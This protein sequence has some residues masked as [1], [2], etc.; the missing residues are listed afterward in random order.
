MIS[1]TFTVDDINTVLTVF[2]T[3]QIRRYTG[4]GTPESPVTD[5]VAF[6]EYTTV[7]GHDVI[8][9]TEGVSVVGLRSDFSQYYFTDP[10]GEASDWYISRYYSSS[11]G[12]ISGWSDA[13]LGEPG[14]LY[15]DPVYP[16]EIEYG[17]ADQIIINRIRRLT[18]DP[19]GLR[20]EYGEEALSSIHADGKTYELDEKGWPTYV[21]MGG[22]SY[23]STSNPSINGY[24]FLRFNEFI[25]EVCTTCTGIVTTCGDEIYKEVTEG[26]DIWYYT[27]RHS[28]R[29][30]MEAYD[31]CPPPPGLT[32]D[33]ATSESY[34][35]YTAIDLLRQE[36]WEDATEDGAALKDEGSHYDPEP[37]LKVRKAL[38]DDLKKRL[39]DVVDASKLLR[40]GG[41]RLD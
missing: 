3:I 15:Y 12:S 17:S 22:K 41:Y 37:G 23:V 7:S 36:L 5:L 28:D 24:R 4:T 32:T 38:L 33:T 2:D 39:K 13:I 31:N 21:T 9:G 40:T 27:F 19:I 14:D 30:I 10:D 11:T 16:V 26:V 8:N 1:L 35:I 29:E 6:S 20:R 25:D 18:G 34:M